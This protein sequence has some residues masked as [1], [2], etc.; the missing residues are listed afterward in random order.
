ME[1][2]VRPRPNY[3]DMLGLSPAA[4]QEE[5]GRAFGKAMGMFA[6]HGA[7]A[8]AQLGIAFETLR[9]PARRR[10]YDAVLGVRREPE[11]RQWTMSVPGQTT[12]GLVAQPPVRPASE[13]LARLQRLAEPEP[14]TRAEPQVE[15]CEPAESKITL[16]AIDA[17]A[18]T[19][20][21]PVIE[22]KRPV[23][24]VAALFVAAGLIGALAGSSLLDSQPVPQGRTRPIFGRVATK[25]PPA[26]S[27][28]A[29]ATAPAPVPTLAEARQTVIAP[30]ARHG[31]AAL[32]VEAAPAVLPAQAQSEGSASATGQA[33]DMSTGAGDAPVASSAVG[34]IAASGLPLAASVMAK[35]IERIGY[36]CGS[37]ASASAA[38]GAAGVYKV[39][40]TSGDTYRAAPVSGRYHFRRWSSR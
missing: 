31:R 11:P 24:T 33:A 17:V 32:Q 8:A 18:R 26:G 1:S 34:T 4:T 39:T 14:L 23:L 2:S 15:P 30:R 13:T 20:D 9:D 29:P 12:R 19:R 21:M 38:D 36:A 5:I 3:Y 6:A 40:C 16:Q 10:A 27:V 25:A 28:A 35:T 37:V 7:Q 22:W